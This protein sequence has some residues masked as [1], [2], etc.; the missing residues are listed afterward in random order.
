MGD[1]NYYALKGLQD[2]H[3]L[4][5]SMGNKDSL[6]RQLLALRDKTLL[7]FSIDEVKGLKVKGPKGKDTKGKD[8]RTLVALEIPA[9]RPGRWVGHPDFRVRSDRV[10]NLLRTSMMPGPETL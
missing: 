3:P 9:P 1:Q 2:P 10:E 6:D 4:T 7:P 5:I 8:T